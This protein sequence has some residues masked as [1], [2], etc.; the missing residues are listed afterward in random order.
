MIPG[1]VVL[2]KIYAV[3]SKFFIAVEINGNLCK[4][5]YSHSDAVDPKVVQQTT[6][7]SK[8]DF[9]RMGYVR[10]LGEKYL[11]IAAPGRSGVHLSKILNFFLYDLET[12]ANVPFEDKFEQKLYEDVGEIQGIDL[13][14][15]TKQDSGYTVDIVMDS[16]IKSYFKV[17]S[18]EMVEKEGSLSLNP[19]TVPGI[20]Q[21]RKHSKPTLFDKMKCFT[22]ATKI[23]CVL[24]SIVNKKDGVYMLGYNRTDKIEPQSVNGSKMLVNQSDSLVS[25]HQFGKS[26]DTVFTYRQTKLS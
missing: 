3:S 26:D 12:G 14:I 1:N 20:R 10:G 18:L 8:A 25:E 6:A 2:T 17:F 24:H 16:A 23:I 22:T 15:S 5:L 19:I 7:E 9:S 4:Y 13:T 11:L 21:G